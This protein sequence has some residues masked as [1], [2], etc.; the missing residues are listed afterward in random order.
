MVPKEVRGVVALVTK[1][2]PGNN[3]MT[4]ANEILKQ[5]EASFLSMKIW[6]G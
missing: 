3:E 6:L 1:Y 4:H 2:C 5:M